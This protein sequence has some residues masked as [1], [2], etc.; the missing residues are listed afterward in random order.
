MVRFRHEPQNIKKNNMLRRTQNSI[1][2]GVCGGI[3]K[4]LGISP[5]VVRTLAILA[6]IVYGFGI[7]LYII[8]WIFIPKEL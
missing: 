1:I 5:L 7:W 2:G 6:L 8:L 3:A 4:W